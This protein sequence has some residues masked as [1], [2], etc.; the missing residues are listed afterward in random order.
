VL[1][2]AEAFMLSEAEANPTTGAQKLNTN[3][4]Q[5]EAG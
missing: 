3:Q 4:F 5:Q 2:E 1:S